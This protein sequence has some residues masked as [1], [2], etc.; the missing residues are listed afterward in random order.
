MTTIIGAGA[1]GLMAAV[2]AINLGM[3]V[4]I[5]EKM[6]RPGIKLGLAGGGRCNLSNTGDLLAGLHDV[7]FLRPALLGLD[8]P[9]LR[10]I[11]A[12]LGVQTKVDELGRIYPRHING[13]ELAQHLHAWLERR[14]VNFHFNSPLTTIHSEANQLVSLTIGNRDIK[15]PRA[16]LACGGHTFPNTGSDGGVA[17][18]LAQAGHSLT[19]LLPALTPVKTRDAWPT[20]LKGIS[21]VAGVTIT[22]NGKR[23][24]Q[25]QGGILFTHFG[26]SGPGVL[27]AS[28]AAAQ[29]LHQEKRVHLSLDL[30]PFLSQGEIL[31]K[32]EEQ[33]QKTLV[34]ALASL[35]PQQLAQAVGS[36]RHIKGLAPSTLAEVA[37]GLKGTRLEIVNVLGKNHSMVS[38]GGVSLREVNPRTMESR[39]IKGL[40]IAG[41]MLDYH[42]KSGGYN[43]HAAFATGWLAGLEVRS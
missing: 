37:R 8:A 35:L 39:R 33:R 9:R 17:E 42:G 41:E 29:A 28:Y 23:L 6:D 21:L 2:A 43:L 31:T 38:Q 19:P 36:D 13:R 34:N 5:Y 30:L 18:I 16:I 15:C 4:T 11:L 14:G 12:D 1:A 27:D 40:F 32:L 25:T 22:G 20:K 24:A 3:P 26:L 10:E 7:K